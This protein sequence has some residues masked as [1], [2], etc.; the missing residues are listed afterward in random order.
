VRLALNYCKVIG[1]DQTN[2]EEKGAKPQI[3]TASNLGIEISI[4]CK[5]EPDNYC[6][7]HDGPPST[8]F[9][10]TD[11]LE[12]EE[13]CEKGKTECQ[14][15]K[16]W[17]G[18]EYVLCCDDETE[19]CTPLPAGKEKSYCKP[20]PNKCKSEQNHCQGLP[21]NDYSAICC[22]NGQTCEIKPDNF[23]I[24]RTSTPTSN[25]SVQ[26]TI[27][28]NSFSLYLP[29]N[30]ENLEFDRSGPAYR[31]RPHGL[32]FAKN[33][34]LKIKDA[35]ADQRI[36]KYPDESYIDSC[37]IKVLEEWIAVINPKGENIVNES[38]ELTVPPGAVTAET[39]ITI[40]KI[41]IHCP[42]PECANP[43]FAII[44]VDSTTP[45]VLDCYTNYE[46]G[47]ITEEE[48][49]NC[50]ALWENPDDPLP[51]P[52]PTG[53]PTPTPTYTSTAATATSTATYAS[54]SCWTS[55][56]CAFGYICCPDKT[57]GLACEPTPTPT[58][59][60]TPTATPTWTPT[61][62]PTPTW[63]P[64]STPTP[65]CSLFSGTAVDFEKKKLEI[66]KLNPNCSLVATGDWNP[67]GTWNGKIC[68]EL[69]F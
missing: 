40:D 16:E 18:K 19:E 28:T 7:T 53:T 17:W 64:T 44:N 10:A 68:L 54:T 23:P 65:T 52:T 55:L 11:R 35:A 6:G 36:Y 3:C 58:P 25:T 31:F 8:P 29:R 12:D 66:A 37:S 34:Q 42:N 9:C 61:A 50:I 56:D 22:D 15:D 59:T 47:N 38:F 26:E 21:P 45:E 51:T 46:A 67:D 2:K 57:C 41:N 27:V 13:T 14:R 60:W 69:C 39:S 43:L 63:T 20:K 1:C 32:T 49:S 4:C 24:C 5:A 62:T 48:F 33:I 30:A